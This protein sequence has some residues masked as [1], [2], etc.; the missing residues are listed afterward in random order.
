MS[1]LASASS[2]LDWT[3]LLLHITK[4]SIMLGCGEH[5]DEV[6]A[7]A[8]QGL[9]WQASADSRVQRLVQGAGCRWQAFALV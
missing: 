9:G 3:T 6:R 5:K 8:E 4:T 1:W 7:Q 2:Q